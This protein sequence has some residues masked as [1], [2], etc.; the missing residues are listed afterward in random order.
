[1]DIHAVMIHTHKHGT[2]VSVAKKGVNI[3]KLLHFHVQTIGESR[4]TSAVM[5]GSFRV[6]RQRHLAESGIISFPEII[7][8]MN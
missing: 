5:P 3:E 6:S 1:M 8:L 4:S 2:K 7:Q